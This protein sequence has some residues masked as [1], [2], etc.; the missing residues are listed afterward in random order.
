MSYSFYDYSEFEDYSKDEMVEE[1]DNS[2]TAIEGIVDE[3]YYEP[4]YQYAYIDSEGNLSNISLDE[5]TENSELE[6]DEFYYGGYYYTFHFANNGSVI[7]SNDNGS[8][9]ELDPTTGEVKNEFI[10]DDLYINGF[11]TIGDSLV[12]VGDE[13][14]KEYSLSKGEELGNIE[15]LENEVLYKNNP[16]FYGINDIFSDDDKTIYYSN[17]NALL[18]HSFTT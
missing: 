9:Y 3:E 2:D 17:S 5:I 6:G 14:V 12:V 7:V 1:V 16:N 10:L 15:A 18:T 4:E 13:S 8:I 11:T